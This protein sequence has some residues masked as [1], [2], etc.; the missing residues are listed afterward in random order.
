M[1]PIEA[2]NNSF[3]RGT[4][5]SGKK[6]FLWMGD[7]VGIGSFLEQGWDGVHVSENPGHAKSLTSIRAEVGVDPHFLQMLSGEWVRTVTP[8][9]IINQFPGPYELIWIDIPERNRMLWYSH[10]IQEALPFIY[11][12][13]EDGHNE[14]VVNAARNR[15]YGRYIAEDRLILTHS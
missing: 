9:E 7:P 4:S 2:I 10:T 3:L 5:R 13:P 11:V 8:S 14:D 6:H 1:T 15:G 12:I